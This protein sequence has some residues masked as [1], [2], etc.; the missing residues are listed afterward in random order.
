MSNT[1]IDIITAVKNEQEKTLRLKEFLD[2]AA[3]LM[4]VGPCII[5]ITEE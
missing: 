2:V 3:G 5:M 1:Y 4:F